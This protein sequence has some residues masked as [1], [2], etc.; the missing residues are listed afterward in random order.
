MTNVLVTGG[1]GGIGAEIVRVFTSH[2]YNVYAPTRSELDLTSDCVLP[3]TDFDIVINS[4]GVNPLKSVLDVTDSTVMT[5]NYLSPLKIIQQ[6]LP[7]MV[8]KQYG[9]IINIGSIWGSISKS[10]R[11]AYSASKSA[12]ESLSR[13]LTAEYSKYDILTNTVS[14]GFIDTPLTHQN[15]TEEA[16]TRIVSNIPIGRLGT[17]SDIANVVY[18]LTVQNTY[19][20]GQNIIVDGG[21]SCTRS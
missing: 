6:C 12:L 18:M 16:L 9:R 15:N 14:P 1:S 4:A 10:H 17:P 5:I 2:G 21:F 19:I 13:S 11:S 3:R 20:T 8:Q 7:H